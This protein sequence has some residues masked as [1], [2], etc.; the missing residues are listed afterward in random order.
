M[1][2]GNWRIHPQ[3]GCAVVLTEGKAL[4]NKE[5]ERCS[6]LAASLQA[7]QH[8]GTAKW[9]WPNVLVQRQMQ[10]TRHENRGYRGRD[11]EHASE[12]LHL[13]NSGVQLPKPSDPNFHKK[14]F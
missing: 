7:V 12:I 8:P 2:R 14:K 9:H 4:Q 1:L 3:D 5:W 6:K 11:P 10:D 13:L